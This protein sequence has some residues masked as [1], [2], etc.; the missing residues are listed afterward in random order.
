MKC[1][2]NI[3]LLVNIFTRTWDLR[4]QNPSSNC[5]SEI[6]S[7]SWHVH[8]ARQPLCDWVI[9]SFLSQ[10]CFD[11]QPGISI[12]FHSPERSEKKKN[13]AGELESEPRMPA[14]T[15][16]GN[17]KKKNK[18]IL[19]AQTVGNHHIGKLLIEREGR[20]IVE[21]CHQIKIQ[22]QSRDTFLQKSGNCSFSWLKSD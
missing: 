8:P 12:Y 22:K 15:R 5:E 21:I 6:E 11:F 9:G 18:E 2:I 4:T 10:G 3:F 17:R 13:L 7:S 14:V 20:E 1:V 16:G 19:R